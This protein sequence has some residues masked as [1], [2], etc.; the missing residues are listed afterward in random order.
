MP[1]FFL[2]VTGKVLLMIFYYTAL[3]AFFEAL[4]QRTDGGTKPYGTIH[5]LTMFSFMPSISPLTHYSPNH[6]RLS[7]FCPTFYLLFISD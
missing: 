2:G 4:T 1:S 5:N 7:I 6:Y 3:K